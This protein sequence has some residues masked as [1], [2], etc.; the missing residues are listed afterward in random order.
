[1]II[2]ANENWTKKWDGLNKE[3]LLN[4]IMSPLLAD[5]IFL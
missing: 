2:W 1:M 3:V 5:D 4:K